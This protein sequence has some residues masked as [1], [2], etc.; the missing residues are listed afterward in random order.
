MEGA[1]AKVIAAKAEADA[2]RQKSRAEADA[3]EKINVSLNENVLKYQQ[4]GAERGIIN[5][6]SSGLFHP[7]CVVRRLFGQYA[8]MPRI[9]QPK[10]TYSLIVAINQKPCGQPSLPPFL[11][12][13]E[14]NRHE[15][16]LTSGQKG[17]QGESRLP[18]IF[19]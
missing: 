4:I 16:P 2:I 8:V 11:L 10:T 19:S 5:V 12:S 13:E 15:K 7:R 9:P 1:G 3:S 18:G 6:V 17:A 14:E